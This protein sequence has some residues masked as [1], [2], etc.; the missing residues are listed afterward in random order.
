MKTAS[1]S[2]S[3]EIL[4]R[5]LVHGVPAD[6]AS[7]VL[8]PGDG[9]LIESLAQLSADAAS[10]RRDGGAS[11][12][13]HAEHLRYTL[14]ML[15]AAKPTE[16]PFAGADWSRAWSKN[17]VTEEEWRSVVSGL[18]DEAERWLADLAVPRDAGQIALTGIIASVVHLAYHF[19]AMRQIDRSI[20]GPAANS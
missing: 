20:A 17:T 13:A 15:N 2:G 16:N 5:E 6:G 11:V 1:L 8:N 14:S 4:F 3:L 9:G 18:R 7:F 10:K 19:G 12:A